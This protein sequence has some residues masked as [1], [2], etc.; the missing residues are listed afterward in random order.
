MTTPDC[1]RDVLPELMKIRL[2]K[3]MTHNE[4]QAIFT[5]SN[6]LENYLNELEEK[7]NG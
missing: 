6:L 5:A 2:N 4:R 1:I 3:K 7:E